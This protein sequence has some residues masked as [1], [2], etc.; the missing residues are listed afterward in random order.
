MDTTPQRSIDDSFLADCKRIHR[1]WDAH[2][3]SLNTEGLIALYAQDTVLETPLV[4]AISVNQL[5]RNAVRKA[6]QPAWRGRGSQFPR[7]SCY[8]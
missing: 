2:A 7:Q 8:N 5:T 4:P 6:T 1:D 3:R